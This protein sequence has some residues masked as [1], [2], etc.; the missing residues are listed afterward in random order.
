VRCKVGDVVLIS[1]KVITQHNGKVGRIVE[2]SPMFPGAWLV[3]PQ[4]FCGIHCMHWADE[5]LIPMP[6]PSWAVIDEMVQRVGKPGAV[7]VPTAGGS[8]WDR[9]NGWRRI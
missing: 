8:T 1:S 5:S 7:K 2:P 3:E 4:M 9:F 6:R